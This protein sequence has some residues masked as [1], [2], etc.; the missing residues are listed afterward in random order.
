MQRILA[1]HSGRCGERRWGMNEQEPTPCCGSGPMPDL[2]SAV[3]VP[4]A[5][6][7]NKR[8]TRLPS[9]KFGSTRAP[10]LHQVW[11]RRFSENREGGRQKTL[12]SKDALLE[13]LRGK[14]RGNTPRKPRSRNP[15]TSRSHEPLHSTWHGPDRSRGPVMTGKGRACLR[16]TYTKAR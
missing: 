6:P 7:S 3:S 9:K 14:H 2:D 11:H 13:S 5:D 12:P 16:K 4:A 10:N 8:M 15:D 1:R